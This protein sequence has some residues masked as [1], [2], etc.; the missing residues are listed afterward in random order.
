MEALNLPFAAEVV[1]NLFLR[2]DKKRN[3]YLVVMPEDKPANLKVL[4]TTPE[5]RPPPVHEPPVHVRERPSSACCFQASFRRFR[6][7]M[8]CRRQ[9][10]Y[11]MYTSGCNSVTRG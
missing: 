9:L 2:D 6:I 10:D 7:L 4:H 3:Y 1:K 8:P 5:N 11:A